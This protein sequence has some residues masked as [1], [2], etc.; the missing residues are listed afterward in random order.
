MLSLNHFYLDTYFKINT[1]STISVTMQNLN[2]PKTL[3]TFIGDSTRLWNKAPEAIKNTKTL[4]TAKAEIKKFV[5]TL[6]I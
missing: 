3:N 1:R 2:E 6:P 4:N 5:L